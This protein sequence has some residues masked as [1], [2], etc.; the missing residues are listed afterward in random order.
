MNRLTFRNT[1]GGFGVIGM[2]ESNEAEKVIACI[3]KLAAYEDTGKEPEE[4]CA[5][6]LCVGAFLPG[7]WRIDANYCNRYILASRNVV[8]RNPGDPLK[9][10]VVWQVDTGH[11]V[12]SGKYCSR[13]EE[14]Q[15]YFA[16]V[17]FNWFTDRDRPE[18]VLDWKNYGTHKTARYKGWLLLIDCM[19]D[20]EDIIYLLLPDAD[21]DD[22]KLLREYEDITGY[23]PEWEVGSVREAMDWIDEY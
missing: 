20:T 1:D 9:E 7:G 13:I 10:F 22:E 17:C 8:A 5:P 18:P 11:D 14:A 23:E 2:N 19:R 16:W 21:W 4:C 6:D 3:S 15:R 12:H